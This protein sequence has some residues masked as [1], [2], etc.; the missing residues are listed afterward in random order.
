MTD[1]TCCVPQ[2]SVLGPVLF[3][4]YINDMAINTDVILFVD[5][6]SAINHSDKIDN[7]INQILQT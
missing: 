1:V 4:L 6:T 5:D 2:G 3:R 7:L